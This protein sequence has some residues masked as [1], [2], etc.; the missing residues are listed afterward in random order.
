MIRHVF[1]ATTKDDVAEEKIDKEIAKMKRLGKKIPAVLDLRVGKN[2]G[3]SGIKYAVTMTVD[4]EDQEGWKAFRKD[5]HYKE[6]V[7]SFSEVF[8]EGA[9]IESQIEC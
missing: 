1:M 3:L 5:L 8:D 6:L 9:F 7:K 2:M 4:L